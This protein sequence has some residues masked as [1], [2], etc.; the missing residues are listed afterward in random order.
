KR[1]RSEHT[2]QVGRICNHALE[3]SAG[4]ARGI[5][6]G[7]RSA[8]A[9]LSRLLAA[10]LRV[11]ETARSRSRGCT[12][13]DAGLFCPA[14]REKKSEHRPQRERTFAFLSACV[15]QTFPRRRAAPCRGH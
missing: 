3:R 12:R 5:T 1:D 9:T 14:A 8:R 7:K 4:G 6:G 13:S 11:C 15:A 2:K 10:T